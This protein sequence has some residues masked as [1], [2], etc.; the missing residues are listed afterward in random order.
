MVSE[1]SRHALLVVENCPVPH[2]R[3]VWNQ[4]R[5]L[6]TEGYDVTVISPS[7]DRHGQDTVR[8]RRDGVDIIRFPMPFGGP[9]KKDFVLE[10][11]WAMLAIHF[12]ALR[13]WF[14]KR[15]HIVHV[16][17]PPDLFFGLKWMFGWRGV[18]FVFDQHD[19]G[20]ETY[21]SKFDEERTG[22]MHRLLLWIEQRSYRASDVVVVTNES[23]RERAVGRG[24][25]ADADVFTVRNSPDPTLFTPRQPVPEL[26]QGFEHLAVFVGTM[27]HQDGAH[28][29]VDTAHYVR[30]TLG[31]TD[32]LFVMVGTGD[33]F[34]EVE[35]RHREL[36]LGEGLRLTG[37]ISDDDMLDYL[38]TADVGLAPDLDSPLN[39]ISTM[40]K[41]MDYMSMSI[42]VVSF[43]LVESKR[44][45]GDA[46]AYV[47]ENTPEAFGDAVVA[48]LDDDA[49]RREMAELGRTR[50]TGDLSWANSAKQLAAAYDR[51]LG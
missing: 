28:V 37:F 12:L 23:Y 45:A 34:D 40:I 42:P 3:R 7:S 49:R 6:V 18:K 27:G 51:A 26:K 1:A 30:S 13:L 44:S 46:A 20:P 9:R 4:A 35:R 31:R 5:S 38:A 24:G 19:L 17:N 32:V 2:D 48:L 50:I 39:N 25:K 22:A 43:D 41:T 16:A 11:G 14:S 47:Q 8:E 10:Y 21:Q 29:V 36:E 33:A 15:F